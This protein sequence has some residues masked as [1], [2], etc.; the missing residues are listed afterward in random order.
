MTLHLSAD[1]MTGGEFNNKAESWAEIVELFP[2]GRV[3]IQFHDQLP[4]TESGWLNYL[5]GQGIDAQTYHYGDFVES[6]DSLDISKYMLDFPLIEA[7]PQQVKLPINAGLKAYVTEQWDSNGAGRRLADALRKKVMAG[8]SPA[9]TVGGK[10]KG[11]F[12]W[13]LKNIAY[14]I[15]RAEYHVGVDSAF[16][17]LAMLYLP[18]NRIR[19]YSQLKNYSHHVHRIIARGATLN[20]GLCNNP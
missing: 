3:V 13:S 10:A 6:A 11:P 2:P 18:A 9:L 14:A 4:K 12:R 17:H 15:S 16:M 1:K 8:Y 20:A 5:R 7:A 19:V